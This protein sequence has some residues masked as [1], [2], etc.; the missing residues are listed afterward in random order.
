MS[1][2]DSRHRNP[3]G[4]A[5]NGQ[6]A[7]YIFAALFVVWIGFQVWAR[8]PGG[9]PAPAG[10]DPMVM[11]ALGVAVAGKSVERGAEDKKQ[12]EDVQEVKAD[13]EDTK[14]RVLDLE[15][16]AIQKHPD[17]ERKLK[18]RKYEPDPDDADEAKDGGHV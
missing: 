14:E 13:S 6:I 9:Q 5:S 8:M 18:P 1:F 11:A 10:L 16:L 3:G 15:Q 4:W 2:R 17:A 12:R 7:V